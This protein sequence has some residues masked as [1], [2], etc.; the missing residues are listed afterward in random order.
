MKP[1]RYV[2]TDFE[3]SIIQP[4]LPN[5]ARGVARVDDH[6]VIDGIFWRLR[7][8]LHPGRHPRAV[9]PIHHLLKPHVRSQKAGVWDRLYA[10][11]SHAY[12]GDLQIVD[13]S[14]IRVH[15]YA[16]NIKRGGPPAAAARHIDAA[17]CVERSRGG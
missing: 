16:A 12:D 7:T 4:L 15:Q 5:K 9:W 3:W 6:K 2:S 13:G 17:G 1:H 14:L 8:G 10:A 11:V